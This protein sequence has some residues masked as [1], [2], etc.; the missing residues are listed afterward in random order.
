MCSSD[1]RIFQ[2]FAKIAPLYRTTLTVEP[3][4]VQA[5]P[6]SAVTIRIRIQGQRPDKLAVL[7]TFGDTRNAEQIPVPANAEQVQFTFR[8]LQRSLTYTVSGGDYTTPVY[9]IDVPLPPQVNL[10]RA[11]MHLPEYTRV[12]PQKLETHGG[13]LEA[14][15]GTRA[16]VTFVL[17]QPADAATLLLDGAGQS[18]SEE[19]TS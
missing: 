17:D 14:L 12:A 10:V 18:R 9:N 7:Q 16:A 5:T 15:H 19:H 4:D 6:G 13:D 11:M 2:P 1:L 3:G 8:N